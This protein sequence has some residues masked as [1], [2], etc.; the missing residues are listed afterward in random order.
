MDDVTVMRVELLKT[1]G[2]HGAHVIGDFDMLTLNVQFHTLLLHWHSRH[3][4]LSQTYLSYC[5][6]TG[7]REERLARCCQ[8]V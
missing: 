5:T 3:L 7:A 8:S 1:I 2:N 6:R 4:A